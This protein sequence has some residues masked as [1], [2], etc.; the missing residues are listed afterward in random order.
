MI[1]VSFFI[2]GF[3]VYHSLNT[4]YTLPTNPQKR[5]FKYRKFLWLD[6]YTFAER[7]VKESSYIHNVFY[8]TAH[9]TWRPWAIKRHRLLIDALKNRGVK[10]ILGKFKE[11]DRYC[12]KCHQEYKGHEEKQTDVNIA[13]Q[14][15]KEAILD[16]FDTAI[17][18]TNDTDLIPAIKALK[19]IF[20]QK[21]VGVLFP[22][23]RKSKELI[24]ECDFY[25]YTKNQDYSKSQFPDTVTLSSGITLTRP[26]SWR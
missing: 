11:K 16:S 13:V 3:N 26:S 9:A 10:V 18:M 6:F 21:K 24:K 1:K 23:K 17:I 8:F 4:F 19:S 15:L 12:T 5:I 25:R 7:F 20:P 2:D 22:L 14:L